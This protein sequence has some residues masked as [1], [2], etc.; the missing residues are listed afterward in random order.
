[1]AHKLSKQTSAL[2]HRA[3]IKYLEWERRN[4]ITGTWKCKKQQASNYIVKQPQHPQ[5]QL[6][7]NTHHRR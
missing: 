5:L 3:L 6:T 7:V 4:K 2:T 1:M